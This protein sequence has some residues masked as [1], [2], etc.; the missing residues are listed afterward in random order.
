MQSAI[1]GGPA[2][3]GPAGTGIALQRRFR[4]SP[5]RVFR[6]W[7]E[8]SAL[9]EWWCPAGWIAGE[10]VIDLRPGGTYRIEMRRIGG[11]ECLAIRGEFLDVT[12]PRRLVFTWI[13]DGAFRYGADPGY[14]R[15]RRISG[16]DAADIEAREFRRSGHSQSAS[17]RLDRSL[18]PARPRGDPDRR[19]VSPFSRLKQRGRMTW[20]NEP[21]RR[22]R[23]L[24]TPGATSGAMVNPALQR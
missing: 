20:I 12:P 23:L 11:G 3:I 5:H 18:Q 6:A 10:I 21:E 8:P 14:S 16:R 13:W 22:R 4:A 17:H 7:T 15:D 19:A 24:A 2:G 1:E 9:R